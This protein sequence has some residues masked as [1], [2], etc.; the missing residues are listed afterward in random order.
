MKATLLWLL[1]AGASSMDTA[2]LPA[3]APDAARG[4]HVEADAEW[5]E[6]KESMDRAVN[7]EFNSDD[8]EAE[9]LEESAGAE[10]GDEANLELEDE[11]REESEHEEEQEVAVHS[12]ASHLRNAHKAGPYVILVLSADHGKFVSRTRMALNTWVKTMTGVPI[13]FIGAAPPST[14]RVP[15]GAQ[16]TFLET[17][18]GKDHSTGLCCKTAT[19]IEQVL[20]LVPSAKWIVRVVD[21]TFVSRAG[22]D[23]LLGRNAAFA[24]GDMLLGSECV[25]WTECVG[26]RHNIGVSHPGGGGGAVLSRAL[27][28]KMMTQKAAFLQH[29]H[30]DDR[31]MGSFLLNWFGVS[32]THTPQVLQWPYQVSVSSPSD[33]GVACPGNHMPADLYYP[34]DNTLRFSCKPPFAAQ[35][36]WRLA[37]MHSQVEL[38]KQMLQMEVASNSCHGKG[39]EIVAYIYTAPGSG[40]QEITNYGNF[41]L[42]TL[43]SALVPPKL[44]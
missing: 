5:A 41:N 39:S 30:Y 28:M 16:V 6:E 24:S 15:Q 32:V 44:L 7:Q 34:F 19:G 4:M 18:C 42:C 2:V 13:V 33:Y 40:A 38:W 21:D 25:C 11:S 37:L 29:C 14:F 26:D 3:D 8:M 27:A 31:D 23:D 10:E 22:L 9:E 20:G 43:P 12:N 1:I 17:N 36:Y 35:P